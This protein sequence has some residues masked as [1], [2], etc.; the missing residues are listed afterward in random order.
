MHEYNVE[1]ENA[2]FQSQHNLN[3]QIITALS[4]TYTLISAMHE[5]ETFLPNA[6][7]FWLTTNEFVQIFHYRDTHRQFTYIMFKHTIQTII[8]ILVVVVY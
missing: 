4:N 6:L 8:L 2:S 3:K 1:K 5:N 7:H